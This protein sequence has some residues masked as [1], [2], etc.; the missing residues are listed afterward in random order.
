MGG[1]AVTGQNPKKGYSG[2]GVYTR[3]EP[4]EI[5]TKFPSRFDAEGRVLAMRFDAFTL[6][7][8]YFPNGKRSEERIKYK[9]AFYNAIYKEWEAHDESLN[10]CGDMNTA[11]KE[12]DLERPKERK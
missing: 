6:F 8:I 12:I 10:I 11:H 4:S 3:H 2:V 5:S 1:I 9:K 7:N